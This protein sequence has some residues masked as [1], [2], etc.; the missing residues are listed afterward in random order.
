MIT[1][2]PVDKPVRDLVASVMAEHHRVLREQRIDV[3]FRSEAATDGGKIV[4]GK[5]RKVTGLASF[6]AGAN[7][8]PFFVLELA[9]DCW[10]ELD[11]KAQRALV[12]HELTHFG[13]KFNEQEELVLFIA[14]HDLEEFN[15]IVKRHGLWR[16]DLTEFFRAA[17]Q[18]SLFDALPAAEKE[19][20]PEGVLAGK[21][22]VPNLEE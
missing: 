19:P 14:P 17:G 12:D 15:V 21:R 4:L 6:L 13:V 7:G 20:L 16:P 5:A 3:V 11:A 10:K 1:Y 8:E 18:L 2:R 9:E 22:A